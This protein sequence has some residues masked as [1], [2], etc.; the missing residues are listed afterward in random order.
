MKHFI[1]TAFIPLFIFACN[2]ENEQEVMPGKKKCDA[3]YTEIVA[4]RCCGMSGDGYI[5][6]DGDWNDCS[7]YDYCVEYYIC[8]KPENP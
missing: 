5:P 4:A 7:S 3:V 6:A 1:L 8:E 2:K